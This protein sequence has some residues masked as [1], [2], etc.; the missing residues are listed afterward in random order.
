MKIGD[1]RRVGKFMFE[2]QEEIVKEK[3]LKAAELC[4]RRMGKSYGLI[5]EMEKSNDVDIESLKPA[6]P[7]FAMKDDYIVNVK[8]SDKQ[9]EEVRELF[10]NPLAYEYVSPEGQPEKPKH[11]KNIESVIEKLYGRGVD[12]K[13][14]LNDK[15]FNIITPNP[16]EIQIVLDYTNDHITFDRFGILMKDFRDPIIIKDERM[17]MSDRYRLVR[18]VTVDM[19]KALL[20]SEKIFLQLLLGS[21][22]VREYGNFMRLLNGDYPVN[23]LLYEK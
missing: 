15:K 4:G 9:V 20:D 21:N 23:Y 22:R 19:K 12:T 10:G 7:E 13:L 8:F 17:G 3:T 6:R 16:T 18:N 2:T 5:A 11:K 1:K 14:L